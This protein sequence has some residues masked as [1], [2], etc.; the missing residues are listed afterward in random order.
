MTKSPGVISILNVCSQAASM[1]LLSV[2]ACP[3]GC[4]SSGAKCPS[5]NCSGTTRQR[6]L[7]EAHP[8]D[9]AASQSLVSLPLRY[10]TRWGCHQQLTAPIHSRGPAVSGGLATCKPHRQH[11]TRNTNG[12]TDCVCYVCACAETPDNNCSPSIYRYEAV[13]S[14]PQLSIRHLWMDRV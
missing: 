9:G 10:S 6:L 11:P 7:K 12:E 8:P 4:L 3:T 1:N 2:P 14:F 13:K 5:V